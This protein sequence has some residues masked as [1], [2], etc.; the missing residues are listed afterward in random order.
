MIKYFPYVCGVIV[1]A[2]TLTVP[3]VMARNLGQYI[4][5]QYGEWRYPTLPYRSEAKE[6]HAITA[7]DVA[8]EYLRQAERA[9]WTIAEITRGYNV[10]Y[11]ESKFDYKA[12]NPK[13]TASGTAQWLIGTW[14]SVAPQG[15]DR[16]D[17]RL[18]ISLFI[19]YFPSNPKWWSEC[20]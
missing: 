14:N 17:Y 10:L 8:Q 2:L 7:S 3:F 5:T 13:S 4:G 1:L 6:N 11:C 20:L 19:E 16:L 15:A 12:D 18:S 9:G